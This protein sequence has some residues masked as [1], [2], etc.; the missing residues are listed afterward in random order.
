[1]R[2]PCVA[3]LGLVVVTGCSV[4]EGEGEVRGTVTAPACGLRDRAYDLHP[5]FF[6]AAH[7]LGRLSIRIQ[8]GS[9]FEDKSDGLVLLVDDVARVHAQALGRPMSLDDPRTPVRMSLYLNETCH[10]SRGRTP[11]GMVAVGGTIEFGGIYL[12][13]GGDEELET[14][15]RFDAVR[16]V[17]PAAPESTHAELSGHFRFPYRRG[18][19]AQRFP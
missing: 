5:D 17:D 12:P 2:F 11:V 8:R 9:D 14:A 3:A 15:G 1:M 7:V 6:G 13:G 4:G 19:P 18:R 10:P 16:L